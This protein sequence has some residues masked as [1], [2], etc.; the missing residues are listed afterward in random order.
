MI[1]DNKKT[2]CSRT[3]TCRRWSCLHL[4]YISY[5]AKVIR[6]AIDSCYAVS[7]LFSRLL[8]IKQIFRNIIL[9]ALIDLVRML[10]FEF[11]IYVP[12]NIICKEK[13]IPHSEVYMFPS[14][15]NAAYISKQAAVELISMNL[16]MLSF[17]KPAVAVLK[18]I[19]ISSHFL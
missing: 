7:C 15:A 9:P 10:S 13:M 6:P 4:H 8:F 3:L 1:C 11:W 17:Y 14:G 18:I 19:P 12:I 5:S 2:I 16:S